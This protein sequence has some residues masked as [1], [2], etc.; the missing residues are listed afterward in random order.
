MI[1]WDVCSLFIGEVV[2]VFDLRL[3]IFLFCYEENKKASQKGSLFCLKFAVHIL[4]Y[5]PGNFSLKQ[6]V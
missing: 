3:E 2:K 5:K 1:T 4:P 6:A